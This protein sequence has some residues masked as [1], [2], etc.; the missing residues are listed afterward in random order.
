MEVLHTEQPSREPL[1]RA[2]K[3]CQPYHQLREGR[4]VK[5]D[6]IQC[7]DKIFRQMPWKLVISVLTLFITGD[8]RAISS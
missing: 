2:K 6:S 1:P 3:L 7:C 8:C 5:E 4:A